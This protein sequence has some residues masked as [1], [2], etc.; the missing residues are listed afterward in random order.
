MS[1][2]FQES[3]EIRLLGGEL[4]LEIGFLRLE[5]FELGFVVLHALDACETLVAFGGQLAAILIGGRQDFF[6]F[7]N[8]G[9]GFFKFSKE[10][11]VLILNDLVFRFDAGN[12][13]GEFLDSLVLGITGFFL[14]GV[15]LR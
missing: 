1:L 3:V 9:G 8:I 7:G 10:A 4:F 15:P 5:G 11:L 6:A 12:A 14:E 13:L 2:D